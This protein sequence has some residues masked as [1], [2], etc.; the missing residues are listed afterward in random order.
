[1]WLL[2][3]LSKPCRRRLLRLATAEVGTEEEEEEAVG[4]RA[5]E[6]ELEVEVEVDGEAERAE[7][8]EAA[9]F[10]RDVEAELGRTEAGR[11]RLVTTFAFVGEAIETAADTPELSVFGWLDEVGVADVMP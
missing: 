2:L 10:E 4:S 9:I 8:E 7:A 5:T 11:V 6:T 3:L 1:M